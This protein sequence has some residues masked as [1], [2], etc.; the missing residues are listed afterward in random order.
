MRAIFSEMGDGCNGGKF[1]VLDS[2]FPP[3]KKIARVDRELIPRVIFSGVNA[4]PR[5]G[6]EVD[7]KKKRG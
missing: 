1:T 6:L 5:N 3:R 7:R 2:R 4:M